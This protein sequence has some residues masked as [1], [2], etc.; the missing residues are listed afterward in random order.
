MYEELNWRKSAKRSHA[1]LTVSELAHSAL[2]RIV[3]A[4]CRISSTP[5]FLMSRVLVS[6][7]KQRAKVTDRH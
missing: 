1:K 6:I 7:N 4:V 5:S 2:W 3:R